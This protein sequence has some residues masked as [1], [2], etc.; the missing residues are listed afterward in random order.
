MN[1]TSISQ[2]ELLRNRQ[3]S[4]DRLPAVDVLQ[5]EPATTTIAAVAGVDV[6]DRVAAAVDVGRVRA[7][8][9]TSI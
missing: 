7:T 8:S 1:R 6:R 2:T 9:S 4:Q 3:D 5:V